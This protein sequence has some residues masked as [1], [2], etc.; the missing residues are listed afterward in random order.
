VHKGAQPSAAYTE[1]LDRGVFQA[2]LTKQE[3]PDI[4]QFKGLRHLDR[5]KDGRPDKLALRGVTMLWNALKGSTQ[6]RETL[7]RY[8]AYLQFKE[9]MDAGK[10]QLKIG[11][12]ASNPALVDAIEDKADRAA[13]LARELIGDYGNISVFGQRMRKYI[14]PFWSWPEMNTKR[15][16]R[17]TANAFQTSYMRGAVTGG[18]LG[19]SVAAR[20]AASLFIRMSIVFALIN[21][22]NRWLHGDDEAKLDDQQQRQLHLILGHDSKGFVYTLRMQGA[23][24]DVFDELGFSDTVEAFK[25]WE[26]GKASFAG[27]LLA[28][29]KAIVNRVGP[30]NWNPLYMEPIQ[31]AL[32]EKLWPDLFKPRTIHDRGRDV[33]QTFS[34][35]NEYDVLAHKPSQGYGRSWLQSFAYQRDPGEMAY[36][37]T[38]DLVGQ[39]MREKEGLEIGRADISPRSEALRDYKLALKFG[40]VDAAQHALAEYKKAGGTGRGLHQSIKSAAPLHPLPK[41]DRKAFQASLTD[42]ERDELNE[43][44]AWYEETYLRR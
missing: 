16:Y 24:S 21:L 4:N 2:G 22:W 7:F 25:N 35:E 18:L 38:R 12:A 1:A 30:G 9:E 19:A 10:D 39:W 41:R 8:A 3:V 28:T 31:L 44:Q 11:Y 6:F 33:A 17:L 26:Q 14:M 20:S 37:N 34:L 5:Q 23:L 29:P 36:N 42:Q 13:L 32:R 27:V 40:D 15:Y 43:A